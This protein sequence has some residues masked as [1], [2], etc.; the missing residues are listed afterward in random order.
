MGLGCAACSSPAEETPGA[1]AAVTVDGPTTGVDA[2]TGKVCSG[3]HVTL[4]DP[5]TGCA[6][7]S[8][9]AC[10]VPATAIGAACTTSGSCTFTCAPGDLKTP[11]GCGPAALQI[12]A[13]RSFTCG[14]TR[15][16]TVRCWG[17][18]NSVM[19]NAP[20]TV[21]G[22]ANIKALGAGT[23]HACAVTTAGAV[24]CWGRNTDGQLGNGTL[25]DSQTPVDVVGLSSGVVAIA[26]GEK[27]TC[28]MLATGDVQCWGDNFLNELGRAA[29]VS[30]T[31][32]LAIAGSNPNAIAIAASSHHTCIV[33][34]NHH[35]TCWGSGESGQLGNQAKPRQSLPVEA[36]GITDAISIAAGGVSI[37]GFTC[38]IRTQG[39][40]SCWGENFWGNLGLGGD[41]ADVIVP[42]ALTTLSGVT[43]LALG[44]DDSCAVRGGTELLCWGHGDY[45]KI[46]HKG[47]AAPNGYHWLPTP[48]AMPELAMPAVH[49]AAGEYHSCFV[50]DAELHCVGS[51]AAG[52]LGDGVSTVATDLPV[53]VAW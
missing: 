50:T 31:T 29:P 15:Q 12:V 43:E 34:A 47:W 26:G 16:H 42:T 18:V 33:T 2:A 39:K 13:G 38:A 4:T 10:P 25:V 46:G 7:S 14:I 37:R 27:H 30:T 45:G 53:L 20:V 28:A 32:P 41:N 49:V 40:V 23:Y 35:V 19:T 9:T 5:A 6:T 22:L 17:T 8:C 1:D 11:T 48:T 52:Q 51:A 3:V 44:V 24:K 36:V 21:P